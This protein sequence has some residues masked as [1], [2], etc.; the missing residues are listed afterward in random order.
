VSSEA[1][2]LAR[3]CDVVHIMRDGTIVQTLAGSDVTET[4]VSRATIEGAVATP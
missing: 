3:L 2:E 1:E 4:S